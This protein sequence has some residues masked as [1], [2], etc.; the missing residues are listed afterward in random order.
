[1]IPAHAIAANSTSAPLMGP[2]GG[3]SRAGGCGS[4]GGRP[5]RWIASRRGRVCLPAMTD[6]LLALTTCPDEAAASA[7]SRSLVESG[8]AACVS[9]LPLTASVY[10]WRGAVVEEAEVLLLVK[11]TRARWP[12]LAAR[13]PSLH[14]YE[15]PELLALPVAEGLPAYLAWLA[16]ATTGEPAP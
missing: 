10:R 9:R 13:L 1:M 5:H 6:A 7:L 16:E 3:L 15:V 11:T 12:D 8:L 4:G 2:A 14:P